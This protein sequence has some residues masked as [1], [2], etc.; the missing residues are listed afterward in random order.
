[1]V[2]HTQSASAAV[3][4]A[5]SSALADNKSPLTYQRR[6]SGG[7]GVFGLDHIGGGGYGATHFGGAPFGFGVGTTGSHGFSSGSHHVGFGA[8]PPSG[9][10]SFGSRCTAK[11]LEQR[12]KQWN[13][14]THSRR[15]LDEISA[16]DK[17]FSR[18]H[19]S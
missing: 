1:M 11:E 19:S 8:S 18:R 16:A 10:G 2:H 15:V 9:C 5:A 7:S 13:R 3:S 4:A 14:T 17:Q 6:P 12:L